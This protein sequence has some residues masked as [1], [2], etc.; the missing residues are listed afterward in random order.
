MAYIGVKEYKRN[1]IEGKIKDADKKGTKGQA[2]QYIYAC[3]YESESFD[4][5]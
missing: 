5:V 3:F 2:A 1:G 4:R